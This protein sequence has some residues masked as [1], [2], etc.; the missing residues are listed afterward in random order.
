MQSSAI[1]KYFQA[2]PCI[3]MHRSK[4]KMA[5]LLNLE[6]AANSANDKEMIKDLMRNNEELLNERQ[7]LTL[8]VKELESKS[9]QFS[10]QVWR[11]YNYTY[12]Y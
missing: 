11:K 1:P 5:F 4:F 9:R 8:N 7:E 12:T 2:E 6:L 3:Y 10:K